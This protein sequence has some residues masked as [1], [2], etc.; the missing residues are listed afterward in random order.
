MRKVYAAVGRTDR[1]IAALEYVEALRMYAA[2]HGKWPE[3]ADDVTD[4]PLP[5]DPITGKPFEY[6]VQDNKA[7]I[8]APSITPGKS[9]GPDAVT[10]EVYLRP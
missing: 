2:A 10:Y 7:V 3:K 1:R 9:D 6:R 5:D 8:A 4:V